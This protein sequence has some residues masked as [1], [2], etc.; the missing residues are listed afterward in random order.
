M[1]ILFIGYLHQ[2]LAVLVFKHGLGKFAEFFSGDPAVH[3]GDAFEA[4]DLEAL[5]LFKD[6][7]VDA[8]FGEGVVCAGV[9]P[10]EATG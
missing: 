3:E 10:C 2:V 4:G 5:A 7:N 6:F 1:K 9:K 8:G